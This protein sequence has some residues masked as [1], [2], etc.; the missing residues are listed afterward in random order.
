MFTLLYIPVWIDL[1]TQRATL[2]ELKIVLYIPV[3]IDLKSVVAR[4]N[5]SVVALYIP[6]WIDLKA[7]LNSLIDFLE[8][9]TFQYG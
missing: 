6:V 7:I 5:S 1:K 9:F 2:Q 3:W 4:E 8:V